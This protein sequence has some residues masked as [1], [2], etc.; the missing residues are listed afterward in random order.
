METLP[1]PA[2]E[3]IEAEFFLHL[4]MGLFANPARLDG[5]S[6][7]FQINIGRQVGEVVFPFA[8][9]SQFTD[10]PGVFAR[11]VL[12]ALVMDALRRAV[13]DTD[14]DRGKSGFE[15]PLGSDAPAQLSPVRVDQHGLRGDGQDIGDG[16]FARPPAL[17]DRKDQ[18][19]IGR[20]DLLMLRD[21]DG[22]SEPMPW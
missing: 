10:K 6:Q 1:G 20:I 11:H 19:D 2:L 17:R 4:L 22:P 3:V 13:G 7:R 5:G 18:R 12:L 21:A 14:P 8:G 9:G 15:R 16:V